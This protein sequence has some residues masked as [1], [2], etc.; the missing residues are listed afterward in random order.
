MSAELRHIATHVK[1]QQ[2]RFPDDT[3]YAVHSSRV[4]TLLELNGNDVVVQAHGGI[5][6]DWR[7]AESSTNV[8]RNS[9]RVSHLERY[10]PPT[11]H[12]G[13]ATAG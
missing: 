13:P 1:R 11:Q 2:W 4:L 7:A 3:V 8:N 12:V 6:V 9:M 5:G 10:Y